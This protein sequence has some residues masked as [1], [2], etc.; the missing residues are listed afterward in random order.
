MYSCPLHGDQCTSYVPPSG[1]LDAEIA[2]VGEGPGNEEIKAR[3]PFVGISGRLL[4]SELAKL[5][6]D[7]SQCFVYNAVPCF[8]G[9]PRTPTAQEV[10]VWRHHLLDVL[11]K[12][13][14]RVI[15]ALGAWAAK[16]VLGGA[17]PVMERLHG[18]VH[19]ATIGDRSVKCVICYHPS[20]VIR[21]SKNLGAFQSDLRVAVETLRSVE[22]EVGFPGFEIVDNEF[23]METMV[24]SAVAAGRVSI[25]VEVAGGGNIWRGGNLIWVGVYVPGHPVFAVNVRNYDVLS[26]LAEP[27]REIFRKTSVRVGHNCGYDAQV[28]RY[29]GLIDDGDYFTDDTYLLAHLIDSNASLSLKE[30]AVRLLGFDK[31]WT[32]VIDEGTG[33]TVASAIARNA[34]LLS[35]NEIAEYNAMDCYACW[36]LYEHLMGH[37]VK[38]ESLH[39]VYRRIVMPASR[40]L[41]DVQWNGLLIDTDALDRVASECSMQ[42]S[43]IEARLNEA[44]GEKVNWSSYKQVS[45][46]LFDKLGLKPVRSTDKGAASTDDASLRMLKGKHEV[47]DLLISYRE[48]SKRLSACKTIRS[49]ISK[50][51]RI[52]AKFSLAGTV[53]GR[54]STSEPNIQNFERGKG[55]RDTVVAP[56]GFKLVEID[57]SQI[58]LRWMAQ[59]YGEENLR[60]ALASGEDIHRRTAAMALGKPADQVTPEERMLGKTANFS[61]GYGAG[62]NKLAVILRRDDLVVDEVARRILEGVGVE[63]EGDPVLALATRLHD[64]FHKLFPGIR[65]AHTYVGRMLS[66]V[67]RVRTVFGRVFRPTLFVNQESAVREAANFIVQSPAA[68]TMWL[69]LPRVASVAESLGGKIINVV[70]DSVLAEIPEGNVDEY[71]ARA[72][73]IMQSPPFHEFGV[74]MEVPILVDVKVGD[75][76]GSLVPV[77]VPPPPGGAA[78]THESPSFGTSTHYEA[79]SG[80]LEMANNLVASATAVALGKSVMEAALEY[81]SRGWSVI[82]VD[83]ASKVPA[84]EWR[85]YQERLPTRAELTAWFGRNGINVGIVTGPV[86][87]LVVVDADASRG[88]LDTLKETGISSTHV[89]KTGGGGLHLYFSYPEIE[90]IDKVK[91]VVDV[92]PGVDVRGAGGYVVAPP[93]SHS[94]GSRYE[95]VSCPDGPPPPLP[96]IIL[97]K[98]AVKRE[99]QEFVKPP[100]GK[101]LP[102]E[103]VDQLVPILLPHWSEGKR[104]SLALAVV[105]L[106]A[107]RGYSWPS[108]ENLVNRLIEMSGDTEL[109]DRF[110]ILQDTYRKVYSGEQVAGYQMILSLVGDEVAKRIY[111]L[112]GSYRKIASVECS[113]LGEFVE[114]VAAEPEWIIGDLL[115]VMGLAQLAGHPGAGKSTLAMQLAACISGGVKFLHWH[116]PKPRR[117]LYLQADNPITMVRSLVDEA[118]KRVPESQWGV[119]IANFTEPVRIDTEGGFEHIAQLCDIYKPE[120]VIF[121]TIRDFHA[122]NEIDPNAVASVIESLKKLRSRCGVSILFIH[123]VA[124]NV[125][126]KRAAIEAH[127]GSMRWVH[128]VDLGLLL[129]TP[130]DDDSGTSDLVKLTFAKVR[131]G[132]KPPSVWLIRSGRWFEIETS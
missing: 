71:V 23:V 82:P 84:V 8:G 34:D 93:S 69:C 76:W 64:A 33:T 14:A 46:I 118:I 18:T 37:I 92:Y 94:S 21:Y 53:S 10:E 119:F 45:S 27:M 74:K 83:P 75:S 60:Q 41:M 16:A 97:D 62:P 30:L 38:D 104:H 98:I 131:W 113:S 79:V 48:W 78:A 122:S 50:D 124:K 15:L 72:T 68:D 29:Y 56:P 52:H 99:R 103:T 49:A 13:K 55:I 95:W 102:Q 54:S 66:T 1:S 81:V 9:P 6:V 127:L 11:S 73:A 61:L 109:G 120:V 47:V 100:A 80:G 58:E 126:Y 89:V 105:G 128:P 44:I 24:R 90:G 12:T 123:H 43:E 35:D 108:V 121:D 130:E 4:W 19:N 112:V 70:H 28:L 59:V 7:R 67:G 129:T 87:K 31:Y 5:G 111:S 132:K 39:A 107:K 86:S 106:L 2:V 115:P 36:R 63:P 85:H 26:L 77:P 3:S 101:V 116:V 51:G 25:D 110:R 17:K 114:T 57:F 88:G 91:S 117:V 65:R 20:A 40:V 22:R 42:V 32:K 96:D 125:G